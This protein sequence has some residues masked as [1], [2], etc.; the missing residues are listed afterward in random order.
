MASLT[1]APTLQSATPTSLTFLPAV[2]QITIEQKSLL[3]VSDVIAKLWAKGLVV[4]PT[5]E[6][7]APLFFGAQS[8]EVITVE[9]L[10]VPVY[11]FAD[12]VSA[13]GR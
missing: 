10:A 2:S 3:N 6:K 8:G 11:E 5:G 12:S 9:K 13:D 1:A 4:N 7:I